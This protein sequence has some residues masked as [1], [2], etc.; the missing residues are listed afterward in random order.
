MRYGLL[1][2]AAALL[3]AAGC[4]GLLSAPGGAPADDGV[5]PNDLCFVCHIPFADEPLATWHAKSKVWCKTCHGPSYAHMND[6][7]IGATR[8]DR[9]YKPG[10]VARMCARCHEAEDHPAV[11]PGVRAARLAESKKAQSEIE[12]RPIVP[13]GLCTDCHGR[14]WVPP[15]KRSGL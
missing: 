5:P 6:E 13:A 4:V 14:H 1:A 9:V 11:P 12:G 2:G 8:P 15:K 7:N 10:Q 3:L